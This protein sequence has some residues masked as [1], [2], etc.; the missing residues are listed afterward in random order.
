MR[1]VFNS[2]ETLIRGIIINFLESESGISFKWD[3]K[4][5]SQIFRGI[6]VK[7]LLTGYRIK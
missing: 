3:E 7:R 6:V 2:F 4:Q 1:K 5:S